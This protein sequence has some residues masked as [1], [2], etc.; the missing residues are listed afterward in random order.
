V[1]KTGVMYINSISTGFVDIPGQISI[2]IYAQGCK[3][4]CR[5]CQNPDLQLFSGGKELYLSDIDTLL[6]DY[7]L[8]K[9]I[10]WLGGDAS[11]QERS[12][13][14]FNKEFRNRGLKVALYTGRQF[15]ELSEDL[16]D[17]LD[18]VID[19]EWNG[20][21]VTEPGSNQSI[22]L[23]VGY[24]WDLICGWEMLG[25]CFKELVSVCGAGDIA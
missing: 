3:K 9:W 2:N 11:Y 13:I 20:I 6:E 18:L 24:C 10:C 1:Q 7:S 25:L 15:E 22:R 21:P 12:L 8:S 14:E 16:L 5:G 4:R 19:G 17:C 23:R